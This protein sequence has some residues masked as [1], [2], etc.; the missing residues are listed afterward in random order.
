MTFSIVGAYTTWD[1]LVSEALEAF[2]VYQKAAGAPVPVRLSTRFINRF[3]V[4]FER[5]LDDFLR[6]RPAVPSGVEGGIVEFSL[7][8][9]IREPDARVEG[10]LVLFTE[11]SDGPDAGSLI[12]D[13]SA[14]SPEDLTLPLDGGGLG[15]A[16][17]VLGKIR[18]FKNKFFFGSLTPY[19]VAQFRDDT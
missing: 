17:E 13:V 7:Q 10:A 14:G 15:P 18:D 11:G 12:L 1:D 16:A 9:R 6:V 8:T 19:M 5:P 4:P 2:D 3:T